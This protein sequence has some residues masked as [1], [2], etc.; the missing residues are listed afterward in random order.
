MERQNRPRPLTLP[1]PQTPSFLSSLAYHSTVSAGPLPAWSTN[2]RHRA[3]IRRTFV[4]LSNSAA[5]I[6]IALVVI[7]G[8]LTWFLVRSVTTA[9]TSTSSPLS[10]IPDGHPPIQITVPHLN[11]D[12]AQ[13]D[14]PSSGRRLH[15]ANSTLNFERIFAINLPS[16]LDRKDLLTV[17]A[18]Y[19]DLSITIVPGVSTIADSA[20]P[21]PRMPG[22]LRIEEYRVWRAHANVWRRVVEDGL[23]TALVL[24]DDNDWD[25]N[26]KEQIPRIL[27]ALEEI[28]LM[29]R[30][31]D[32][33]EGVVRGGPRVEEWDILYL[34]TC[35]E[36]ATLSD[37]QGRQT[38]V[39][40]PS[41]GENVASHNYNWVHT[42]FPRKRSLFWW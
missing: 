4:S 15:E 23:S 13:V 42:K 38:V 30:R 35:F 6:L 32:E 9:A 36:M 17:M 39:P 18:K 19:T 22:S 40:I 14:I 10:Q 5:I 7:I 27:T 33:G 28:R 12:P 21:P 16:R 1:S 31:L 24:E 29:P 20:I 25:V 3:T 8:T 34:G 11:T 41:D 2:R 26:L 37:K